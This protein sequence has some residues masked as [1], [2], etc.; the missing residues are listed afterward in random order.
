[1]RKKIVKG[2]SAVLAAAGLAILLQGPAWASGPQPASGTLRVTSLAVDSARVAD[3][4]TIVVIS[5]SGILSGT[6]DGPFTETDREVIHP[7]G[8]VTLLGMGVQSGKLGTCGTGSAAYVTEAQGTV[9]AI[10]G[11]IQFTDQAAS[12][13]TPTKMHSVV[14]FAANTVTGEGAYTGTYHCT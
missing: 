11:R 12:T 9:S 8:S 13:S 1:M 7:D 10:S 5:L 2:M 3:G 14:T 6:L 4:N